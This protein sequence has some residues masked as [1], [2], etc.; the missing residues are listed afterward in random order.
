MPTPTP[1]EPISLP[2]LYIMWLSVLATAGL[3]I[4]WV[5]F[6]LV[7]SRRNESIIDILL[8]PGF[9]KV[10]AVMGIIAATA[11]LALAGRLPSNLTA[12]ILSGVAGYVLGSTVRGSAG[13]SDSGG[14]KSL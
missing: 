7:A 5:V 14:G 2:A 3:I 10:I 11:V 9:F 6:W 12:A 4:M 8:S 13:G 1:G